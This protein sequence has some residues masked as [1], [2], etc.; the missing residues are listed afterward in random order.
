MRSDLFKRGAVLAV[1]AVMLCGSASALFGKKT[2]IPEEGAPTVQD[3]E[4]ITYRGIPYAAQF[5]ASDGEGE[6]MTFAVVDQPRKGTVTIDGV[7]FTYTPDEDITGGDSFTYAATDSSGKTS[8]PA[9]VTVTIQKTRSGVTYADTDAKSAY[10]AQEMAEKGIFTGAKIGDQ[11]YF[12]PDRTVS[13]SEFLA[14][15]M[16]M[17]GRDVTAV[18][19]TGFSDDAAIPTWA[20]AYAAAG[21]ADGIV[22][23]SATAQGVA[24]RSE[25][26]I[27]F[28]EAASLLNRVLEIENVDLDVWYADRESVPT[29]AS[30]A[31]GNL[32]AVSVLQTGS[33][34]SDAMA[35]AVTRADAAEMLVSASALLTGEKS[36]DPFDW[37]K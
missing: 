3:I 10:A 12:E 34:G 30:Q 7:N 31:V 1:A 25:E 13:R 29:W 11:Y 5:L 4:I 16:E 27:T 17:A 21:V 9:T 23:G 24:F 26:S 6:D 15:T 2:E 37:L 18:T 8:A 22:Q 32:E 20:K 33:F 28:N 35:Q 36:S 14:M 19:M